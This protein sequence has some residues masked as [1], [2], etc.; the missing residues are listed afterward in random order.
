VSTTA[1][2]A[3]SKATAAS[4]Q[5]TPFNILID[6]SALGVLLQGV[7][8]AL[9]IREGQDN[10]SGWVQV[11]ARGAEVTIVLA[12]VATIVAF[13]GLVGGWPALQV[14]HFP[15]AMALLGLAVWLPLRARGRHR[16]P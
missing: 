1:R 7:W 10:N 9:F 3:V 2:G 13:G 6:L 4:V 11:H 14:V 12:V 16:Q 5:S 8:T 15:L